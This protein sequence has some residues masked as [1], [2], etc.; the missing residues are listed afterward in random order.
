VLDFSHSNLKQQHIEIRF[1][2]DEHL[3]EN[4][5]HRIYQKTGTSPSNQ[6]LYVYHGNECLGDLSQQNIAIL[7]NGMRIH[8]VDDNPFSIS[9]GGSLENTK[10]VEKFRLTDEQYNQKKT[11]LRAWARKQQEENPNFTLGHVQRYNKA[12]VAHCI[13]SE[14]CQVEPGKRRGTIK[15]TGTFIDG[16]RTYFV[17][18]HLDEPVGQNDG[19]YKGERYFEN[20]P[21]GYGCFARGENVQ[22][23]PEFVDRGMDSDSSTSSEDE[24]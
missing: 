5:Q 10:L 12:S 1:D 21:Q 2:K 17:G 20:C 7:R 16:D 24:I 19:T 23:G 18:V 11:T 4:I 6:Q 3:L 13:I 8:C 14:R 9:R 15:W 22:C